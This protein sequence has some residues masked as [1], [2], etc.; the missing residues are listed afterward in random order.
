MNPAVFDFFLATP[1]IIIFYFQ[2]ATLS[3]NLGKWLLFTCFQNLANSQ[4]KIGS[5][6]SLDTL[7]LAAYYKTHH[8][9]QFLPARDTYS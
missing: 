8:L 4:F 5:F 2:V 3:C 9:F 6:L 7:L 1:H